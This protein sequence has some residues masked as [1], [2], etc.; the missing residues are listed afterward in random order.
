MRLLFS[1]IVV[2]LP[3]SLLK[4]PEEATTATA[5]K[6]SLQN[7]TLRTVKYSAIFLWWSLY[8]WK[9]RMKDL[10]PRTK[11]RCG[12][13]FNCENFTS[14]FGRLSQKI[15]PKSASHVQHDYFS[16]FIQSINAMIGLWRWRR[17]RRF[18]NSLLFPRT[19]R[20]NMS[21]WKETAHDRAWNQ[22]KNCFSG[23]ARIA[24]TVSA[25]LL[26]KSSIPGFRILVLSFFRSL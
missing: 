21:K 17:R 10:L 18:F 20:T 16:S 7:R 1:G 25:R 5:T 2:A 19:R 23:G 6:T 3:S 8:R 13:N 14:S 26:G 4:L 12:Q 9:H 11:L 24:Q 22:R 15:A